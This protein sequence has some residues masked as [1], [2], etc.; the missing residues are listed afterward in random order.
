M[1]VYQAI[2]KEQSNDPL[3]QPLR[4][5][6]SP[7]ASLYTGCQDRVSSRGSVRRECRAPAL[8][9]SEQDPNPT[10]RSGMCVCVWC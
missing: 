6:H 2:G 3:E 10:Q 1:L 8:D 9:V 7:S 4:P 5:P